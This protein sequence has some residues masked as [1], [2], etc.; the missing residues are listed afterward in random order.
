[1][2]CNVKSWLEPV[3][4]NLVGREGQHRGAQVYAMHLSDGKGAARI[5][6]ILDFI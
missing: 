2:G 3:I 1:V 5:Y 6:P 4:E